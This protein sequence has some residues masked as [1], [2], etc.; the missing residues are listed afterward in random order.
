[1]NV[2][3][4][5]LVSGL[6]SNTIKIAVAGTH[7][8]AT[9]TTCLD[10][11]GLVVTIAQSGSVTSSVSTPTTSPLQTHIELNGKFN[12]AVGDI[13]T[14]TTASSAPIDQPPN[15]IKTTINIKQGV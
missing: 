10:P 8:V 2:S 9:K 12:C 15:F 13:I 7:T 14:V 4:Q 6:G 5:N 1:M 11:S 3:R